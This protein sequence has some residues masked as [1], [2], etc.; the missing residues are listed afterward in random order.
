[1][2]DLVSQLPLRQR[3]AVVLR[4]LG[5][6]RE[7]EIATVMGVRRGTVSRHLRL[8]YAS[9]AADTIDTAGLEGTCA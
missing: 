9:L 4:H 1:M 3:T 7:A 5:Q 8:A 2:W 6:L